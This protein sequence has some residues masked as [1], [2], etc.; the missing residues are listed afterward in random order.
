MYVCGE[1]SS[2]TL[3][4]YSWVRTVL[5]ISRQTQKCRMK[6]RCATPACGAAQCSAEQYTSVSEGF[7]GALGFERMAH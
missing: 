4:P 1:G 6:R 7:V 2:V 3:W 5:T